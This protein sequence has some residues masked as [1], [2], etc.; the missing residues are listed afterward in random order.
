[1]GNIGSQDGIAAFDEAVLALPMS[2]G[3]AVGAIAGVYAAA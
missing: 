3:S 1:M 2:L